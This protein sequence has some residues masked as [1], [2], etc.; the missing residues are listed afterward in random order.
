M[1]IY[2]YIYIIYI[3]IQNIGGRDQLPSSGKSTPQKVELA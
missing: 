3:Y 2:I 1:Y